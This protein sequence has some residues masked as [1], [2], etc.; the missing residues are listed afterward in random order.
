MICSPG[1]VSVRSS[2]GMIRGYDSE[3]IDSLSIQ[4]ANARVWQLR[5]MIK[6]LLDK[7]I[8][9]HSDMEKINDL[10]RKVIKEF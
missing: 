1:K 7:I 9:L 8:E 2:T 10:S 6:D 5:A 4:E 3:Y